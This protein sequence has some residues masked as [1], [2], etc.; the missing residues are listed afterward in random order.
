MT[1]IESTI[2]IVP[3][4]FDGE[5]KELKIGRGGN[6]LVSEHEFPIK[7]LVMAESDSSI[8]T[9]AP[10]V[11]TP[12]AKLTKQTGTHSI[13]TSN[14]FSAT[15]TIE[16]LA[17]NLRNFGIELSVQDDVMIFTNTLEQEV[18]INIK[19][20]GRS[21][22]TYVA[23]EQENTHIDLDGKN[24]EFKLTAQAEVLDGF[25]FRLIASAGFELSKSAEA[26]TYSPHSANTAGEHVLNLSNFIDDLSKDAQGKT[27]WSKAMDFSDINTNPS[28]YLTIMFSANEYHGN[29]FNVAVNTSDVT[30]L[31]HF[32]DKVK[33]EIAVYTNDIQIEYSRS[34]VKTPH[35]PIVNPVELPMPEPDGRPEPEPDFHQPVFFR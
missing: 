20:Q 4:N 33:A 10:K 11:A 18:S 34:A 8:Y 14:G 21:G 15:G 26:Y 16:E 22:K 17:E 30:T 9:P 5:V 25:R 2:E 19:A 28:D 24:A 6:R 7:I 12:V 13:H 1:N 32:F 27:V 31:E 29:T 3:Q 35:I 23:I